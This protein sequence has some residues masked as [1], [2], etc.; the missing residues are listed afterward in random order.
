MTVGKA[1]FKNHCGIRQLKM[2]TYETD[3]VF[4]KTFHVLCFYFHCNG[5]LN[6]H[7]TW[8][9]TLYPLFS[10]ILSR[11]STSILFS[12]F[13]SSVYPSLPNVILSHSIGMICLTILFTYSFFFTL[14]PTQ[15]TRWDY[16]VLWNT[17]QFRILRLPMNLTTAETMR[18]HRPTH[19]HN[20]TILYRPCV[21]TETKIFSLLFFSLVLNSCSF[22]LELT[23]CVFFLICFFCSNNRFFFVAISLFHLFFWYF[24][25]YCLALNFLRKKT[26]FVC[27][28]KQC[29]KTLNVWIVQKKK[30]GNILF[31]AEVAQLWCEIC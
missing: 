3:V 21:Y 8:C 4:D 12:E 24:V 11:K 26:T 6:A 19:T 28:F 22:L 25:F 1:S 10:S 9:D 20:H 31:V 5:F 14:S 17:W 13:L 15:L 2:L 16:I 29:C 18:K 23:S 30:Y 7:L 27:L